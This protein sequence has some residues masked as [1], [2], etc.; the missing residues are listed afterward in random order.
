MNRQVFRIVMLVVV[1]GLAWLI[2][3]PQSAPSGSAGAR[4]ESASAPVGPASK[5]WGHLDSLPEHFAKHG[6]DFGARNAED[7]AAQAAAFLLRAKAEGLPAKR[8]A[9]GALRIYDPATG[10]FGAYNVNGT[11]RTYFKPGSPTYFERQPG[12]NVDLRKGQ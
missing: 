2:K 9:D 8:D 4:V 5:T 6:T 1:L 3:Q 12:E 7:Y 11:T 10:A